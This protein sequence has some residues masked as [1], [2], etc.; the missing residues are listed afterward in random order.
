MTDDAELQKQFTEDLLALERSGA[1][2]PF[3]FNP[4]EAFSL[5]ALL[6]L[7]LRHPGIGSD[8]KGTGAFGRALAENIQGRLCRTPAMQ[9]VA[10]R[11]WDTRYDE[12]TGQAEKAA[13]AEPVREPKA[14]A[15][16]DPAKQGPRRARK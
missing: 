4:S 14:E 3:V 2:M 9:E 16:P 6:Q 5:L 10:R 12:K 8:A 7:A 1:G 11:G 15:R 13:A